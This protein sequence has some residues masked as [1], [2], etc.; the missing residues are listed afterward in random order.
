MPDRPGNPDR[1]WYSERNICRTGSGRTLPNNTMKEQEK[2]SLPAL[3]Q[4]LDG[5][6][7]RDKSRFARRLHGAK[8]V[9][10]PESREAVLATLAQEISSA[11]A[12]VALR[13]AARPAIVY[14]DNLPVSQ[15]KQAILEA[16]RDNQVVIVAGDYVVFPQGLKTNWEVVKPLRKHYKHS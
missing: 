13:E 12:K 6:M 15:K 7:L 3:Q 10:N 1:I 5:L 11:A 2:I 9:K 8:K 4:Q 16:V 14:P